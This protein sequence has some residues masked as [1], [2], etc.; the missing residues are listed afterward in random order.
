MKKRK[1]PKEFELL[2][3]EQLAQVHTWLED[4]IYRIVCEK[5]QAHFGIK[6]SESK[7][8]RY[9]QLR[10]LA[11]DLSDGAL[12]AQDLCDM[13]NGQPTRFGQA[14]IL[15]LQKRA[16]D[17]AR[18]PKNSASKLNS[19]LRVLSYDQQLELNER[20]VKAAE[21]AA[22]ARLLSAEAAIIRAF[23]ASDVKRQKDAPA[24]ENPAEVVMQ[25]CGSATK[26]F[27]Q[28]RRGERVT[29][30][31][32]RLYQDIKNGTF[33]LQP[34][35][36]GA[37]WDADRERERAHQVQAEQASSST[38]STDSPQ[39]ENIIPLTPSEPPTN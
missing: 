24:P 35:P 8:C 17:L 15:C 34:P 7:L 21:T 30:C 1:L 27:Q 2:T 39:E 13:F 16:F 10:E 4:H 12:E 28:L 31:I 32:Q 36:P 3:G 14:G 6:M 9:N 11:L 29:H 23:S 38:E 20:R 33:V 37:D 18:D 26:F 5:L 25:R 19:L 22:D